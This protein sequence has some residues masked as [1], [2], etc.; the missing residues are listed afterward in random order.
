MVNNKIV[1]EWI[2]YAQRDLESAKYLL[3]MRPIPLEIVCYHC[4]QAAEKFLKSFL[5]SNIEQIKRI[6]DLQY[7]CKLCIQFDSSF[8]TL[9][10]ACIDLTEYCIQARY[11]FHIDIE[12]SDMRLAI[13]NAELIRDSIIKLKI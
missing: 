10:D 11:P 7:L 2:D 12:E 8:S 6:H 1:S 9:E 5:I 3:S 13:K 4:Q